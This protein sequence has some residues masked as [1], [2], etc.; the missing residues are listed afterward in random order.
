MTISE[1]RAK[2]EG[3]Y[4]LCLSAVYVLRFAA[5]EIEDD[6]VGNGL[7]NASCQLESNLDRQRN[8]RTGPSTST[9]KA[10]FL[11]MRTHVGPLKREHPYFRDRYGQIMPV[12][13]G[14]ILHRQS[15]GS[16]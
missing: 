11:L 9:L 3:L 5:R 8:R 12:L 14:E 13:S 15:N 2:D 1:R 10:L 4:E 7:I 6:T 16:E